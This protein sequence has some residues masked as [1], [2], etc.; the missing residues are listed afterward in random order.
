M[1]HQAYCGRHGQVEPTKHVR[2]RGVHTDLPQS[3]VEGR[4]LEPQ[5][6]APGSSGTQAERAPLSVESG[7]ETR[8]E[9]SAIA[10]STA[11]PCWSH[12]GPKEGALPWF[13]QPQDDRQ[14]VQ[15]WGEG[16]TWSRVL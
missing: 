4:S 1:H 15:G 3:V 14:T 16:Q 13:S 6:S 9:S 8:T 11:P 12:G 7:P 2:A 5:L 10:Y